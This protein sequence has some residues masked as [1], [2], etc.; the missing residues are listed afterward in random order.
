MILVIQ[1]QY[2]ENYGAHDW[3]GEGACPQYWKMKGGQEF[4]VTG[5]TP[6]QDLDAIVDCVRERIEHRSEFARED[7][8]GYGL[9][10]DDY[11]SWF[12]KSQLEYDGAIQCPETRVSWISIVNSIL[13][14]HEQPEA[15]ANWA[16]DID[17]QHY[18]EAV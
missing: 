8:I 9:E 14:V 3:D 15:F 16:A 17:A 5:I 4:M 12:E 18:G 13:G 11:M 2:Q 6:G 7:I 10:A 1:T